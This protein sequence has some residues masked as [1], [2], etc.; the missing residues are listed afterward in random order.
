MLRVI[1]LAQ[2]RMKCEQGS[3]YFEMWVGSMQSSEITV[4]IETP[5]ESR[6]K[7][8]FDKVS[9]RYKVDRILAKGLRFPFNFGFVPQTQAPDGD[10]TDILLIIDEI[11]FPG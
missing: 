11:L 9:G 5:K 1:A 7:F 3:S 4:V 2:F 10:P 8:K 6:L